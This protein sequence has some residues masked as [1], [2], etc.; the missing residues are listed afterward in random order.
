MSKSIPVAL[1]THYDLPVTTKTY[2][3]LVTPNEGATGTPT[4]LGWTTLDAAV[5][6]NEG[7]GSVSYVRGLDISNILTSG[8][9]SIDNAD[10]TILVPAS[11][12][13][14]L[15]LAHINAG[16]Y[17]GAEYTLYRINYKDLT[18]ARH[19]VMLHGT[20]GR[21][22][23]ADGLV[24]FAELRGLTQQAKQSA[25]TVWSI[26]CRQTLATCGFNIAPEWVSFTVTAVDSSEPD[27]VFSVT[28]L[29]VADSRMV[30]GVI[31]WTAG[32]NNGLSDEVAYQVESAGVDVINLRFPSKFNVAVGNT[33]QI[34]RECPRTFD[35]AGCFKFHAGSA[36]LFFDGEPHIPTGDA[37]ALGTPGALQPAAN[38]G[39]VVDDVYTPAP[40]P[41]EIAAPPAGAVEF[42]FLNPNFEVPGTGDYLTG[43]WTATSATWTHQID[44]IAGQA[45]FGSARVSYSNTAATVGADSSLRNTFEPTVVAGQQVTVNG[46]AAMFGGAEY[47]DFRAF[48]TIEQLDAGNV[49]VATNRPTTKVV[50]SADGHYVASDNNNGDPER[51]YYLPITTKATI[52]A[53]VTHIRVS[54]TCTD[55]LGFGAGGDCRFDG[56][57]GY[58]VT[59]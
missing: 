19:E 6:Y 33:G 53:T 14:P 10:A 36:P 48:I 43:F 35:A 27:R 11:E 44:S 9:L 41:G 42:A 1:Q 34:R 28:N 22:R 32:S 16:R 26:E 31:K 58:K 3:L 21:A 51:F 12:L 52:L 55:S 7:A 30:P 2:L 4:A 39:R 13:G 23:I 25:T 18:T 15:T 38:S 49:V 20:V 54:F 24:C 45:K 50:G 5:A 17:D 47:G 29:S 8:D 46:W 40:D 37:S 56:L 59:P 57:S